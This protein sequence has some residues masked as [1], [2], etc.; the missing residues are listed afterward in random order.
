MA[1]IINVQDIIFLLIVFQLLLISFNLV[2]FISEK[3]LPI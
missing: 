2:E 1:I 3:F